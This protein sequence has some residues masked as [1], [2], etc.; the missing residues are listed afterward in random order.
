[1]S[2]KNNT[3]YSNGSTP[4]HYQASC[5]LRR[6]LYCPTHIL[7]S[8]SYSRHSPHPHQ[9]LTTPPHA[10]SHDGDGRPQLSGGTLKRTDKKYSL[11]Q[12]AASSSTIYKFFPRPSICMS[13]PGVVLG[14]GVLLTLVYPLVPQLV[15]GRLG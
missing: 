3:I 2:A 6:A 4:Y 12:W 7:R 13:A 9:P 1:M 15:T 14:L 5:H 11:I 10:R 8:P